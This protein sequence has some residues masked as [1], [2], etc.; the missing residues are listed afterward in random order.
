MLVYY[1]TIV[2]V[3]LCIWI[4]RM[5]FYKIQ[6]KETIF[7]DHLLAA[8]KFKTGDVILFKAFNNFNSIFHGGYF[9]HVGIVYVLDGV[10]MLFE[11]NG[12]EYT[13]L[14]PHHSKRGIFFTP[15]ADRIKKYKGTCYLKALSKPL[16]ADVIYDFHKFINYTLN[17]FYYDY[18]VVSS[19]LKRCI[20]GIRCTKN[21]DCGQLVFL[22]LIKLGLLD[23]KEYDTNKLHVLNYVAYLDKLENDYKFNE[24]IQIQDHPFNQ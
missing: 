15:L 19:S 4:Y 9:G 8:N 22:S 24:L 1:L 16:S 23:M 12:I 6:T 18:N 10:P 7:L 3:L 11:A 17:N 14:M 2:I 5:Q 21:T 20:Q 13:P